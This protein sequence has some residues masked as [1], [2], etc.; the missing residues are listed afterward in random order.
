MSCYF[1]EI[2]MLE[3]EKGL[4]NLLVKCARIECRKKLLIVH[5]E[6]KYGFCD[7]NLV[8]QVAKYCEELGAISKVVEVPFRSEYPA[9]S[10]AMKQ[11]M[12]NADV[13]VFLARLADQLRFQDFP[14]CSKAIINYASTTPRL[15]SS[16]G[17]ADYEGFCYLKSL[18]DSFLAKAQEI[19][20][21]CPKGTNFKGSGD[22][23]M[24]KEGD[25]NIIRF[26]MLVFSPISSHGYQG[27]LAV[28]GFL[29]GTSC[30]FYPNYILELDE[31]LYV[32]FEGNRLL[33]FEG[34]ASD[35][36]KANNHFDYVS[37]RYGLDR[38]RVFSWHAGIHPGNIYSENMMANPAVWC[39]SIF[40]NPRLLHFHTCG[41]QPPGEISWNV[42]DP[43]I[44]VDGVEIWSEGNLNLQ[45][46]PG[47]N[48]IL[49]NYQD[50]K[51]LFANPGKEIGLDL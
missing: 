13:V 50:I 40:G 34:K 51:Q 3:I 15:A 39:S 33:G 46:L 47:A 2:D 6:E 24:G 26:P 32:T 17:Q 41:N 31:T 10:P 23:L 36:E 20:V 21:T 42:I 29:I 1:A 25:V 5:E 30:N 12:E 4:N 14:N 18:L 22:L 7:L 45:K 8:S 28:P 37:K 35:V 9:I 49:N 44:R 38:N 48:M 19:E 43:T 11:A 16:F 27:K